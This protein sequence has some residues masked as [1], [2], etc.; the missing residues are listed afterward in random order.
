MA[1]R[2][3]YIPE[4]KFYNDLTW[5][6]TSQINP[7]SMN[8]GFCLNEKHS[9]ISMVIT[10]NRFTEFPTHIAA[11]RLN[12]LPIAM[13]LTTPPVLLNTANDAHKKKGRTASRVLSSRTRFKMEIRAPSKK[14]PPPAAKTAMR[15]LRCC[16]RKPVGSPAKLKENERIALVPDYLFH[17]NLYAGIRFATRGREKGTVWVMGKMFNFQTC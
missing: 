16:G 14:D 13:G 11:N 6:K 7:S 10:T 2:I 1:N 9:I 3:K 8:Y 15:S 12:V 17:P 5:L 4:I